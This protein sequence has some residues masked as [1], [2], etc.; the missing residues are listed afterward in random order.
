MGYDY[1]DPY[2]HDTGENKTLWL[3]IT[4]EQQT[5]TVDFLTPLRALYINNKRIMPFNK[6]RIVG[7]IDLEVY[8]NEDWYGPGSSHVEKIEFYIDDVLKE[9]IESKPYIWT[10]D[11]KTI[12]KH[13][14]K[15][16]AYD[17]EGNTDSK[18]LVVYKFL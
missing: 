16:I 17:F 9:T 13:T 12:G 6:V 1:Y 10:W 15:V 3:N 11:E 18:D 8:T 14:I 7:N 4:L 2:R 5:I